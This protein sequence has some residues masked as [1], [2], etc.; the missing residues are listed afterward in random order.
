MKILRSS[1]VGIL[2][3]L[4][5]SFSLLRISHNSKKVGEKENSYN[6]LVVVVPHMVLFLVKKTRGF[7]GRGFE[8]FK[9]SKKLPISRDFLTQF[10]EKIGTS[11]EEKWI[12]FTRQAA[13]V[14]CGGG[15]L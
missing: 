2:F 15:S 4:R 11:V 10:G 8:R 7:S 1:F 9:N 6:F 14:P 5:K 3:C 12:F 13:K